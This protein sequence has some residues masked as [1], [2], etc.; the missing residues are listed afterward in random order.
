MDNCDP[1]FRARG[2]DEAQGPELELGAST[3]S[4]TKVAKVA[5]FHGH[6]PILNLARCPDPKLDRNTQPR[7][8]N[9][10]HFNHRSLLLERNHPDNTWR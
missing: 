4:D 8:V 9:K 7:L 3:G 5:E 2:I 1:R 6:I 10:K